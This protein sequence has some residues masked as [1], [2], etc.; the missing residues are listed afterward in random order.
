[1]A[2]T[3][4]EIIAKVD[5]EKQSG[6]AISFDG[7]TVSVPEARGDDVI[8]S[9]LDNHRLQGADKQRARILQMNHPYVMQKVKSDPAFAQKFWEATYDQPAEAMEQFIFDE[10]DNIRIEQLKA[11]DPK[12]NSDEAASQ[13]FVDELAFGQLGKVLR[14]GHK[15][16]S[17]MKERGMMPEGWNPSALEISEED[18]VDQQVE[19]YRLLEKAYP[20]KS[21]LSRAAAYA[22]P[23][24][25]IGKVFKIASEMLPA[26]KMVAK[27]AGKLPGGA[28]MGPGLSIIGKIN[29]SPVM[30]KAAESALRGGVGTAAVR[31]PG[32]FFGRG[33]E[34]FDWERGLEETATEGLF[35]SFVAGAIPLAAGGAVAAI[36]S[37]VPLKAFNKAGEA[38]DSAIAFG[39]GVQKGALQKYVKNPS[40]IKSAA[41]KEEALAARMVNKLLTE[42][43]S[44]LPERQAADSLLDQ[45]PN[46]DAKAMLEKFNVPKKLVPEKARQVPDL[47]KHLE[48][49]NA[50]I[51]ESGHTPDSVPS[52]VMREIV[53]ELQVSLDGEFGKS[54]AW[55]KEILKQVQGEGRRAIEDGASRAGKVGQDYIA[56]MRLVAGK[57][58]LLDYM[59]SKLGNNPNRIEQNSINFIKRLYGPN[60]EIALAKMR[61]FDQKFKTSF[62]QEIEN[63]SV[64]NQ[65]GPTGSP[66]LFPAN[67]LTGGV[68]GG[69]GAYGMASGV[70]NIAQG[71]IVQGTAQM[72]GTAAMAAKTSPKAMA[73]VMGASAKL[74]EIPRML[75]SDPAVL[76]KI[77]AN[78]SVPIEIKELAKFVQDAL[79]K[80][81]PISAQ[82]N[83]RIIADSPYF[84]GLVTAMDA[85]QQQAGKAAGR[86]VISNAQNESRGPRY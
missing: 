11:V 40:A 82:S 32:N 4:N 16:L 33:T 80:D 60:Q 78:G 58:K 56:N 13:A 12:F 19:K 20:G 42:K 77:R 64:A 29:Q 34:D 85:A 28:E 47:I 21:F 61:A 27:V 62:A 70:S 86:S 46:V 49:I 8:Q 81:G 37:G 44:K 9:A 7:T 17:A 74:G 73:G 69:S 43:N 72:I 25:P 18:F 24:S 54:S 68:L 51:K 48:F 1:M 63:I 6:K 67:R 66:Q 3:I 59:T 15:A 55:G 38:V 57:R 65:L 36:E 39:T 76:Q 79:I 35:G 84:L 52:R 83:L 53:D 2:E 50:R 10:G 5:S 23:S 71:N 31:A 30:R 14:G 22:I 26:G 45:L 41:G 75:L